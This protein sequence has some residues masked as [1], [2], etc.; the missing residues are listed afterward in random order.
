MIHEIKL[1]GFRLMVRR[2]PAGV[3]LVTRNGAFKNSPI[4]LKG[5]AKAAFWPVVNNRKKRAQRPSSETMERIFSRGGVVILFMLRT[6]RIAG[7]W[8]R[9]PWPARRRPCPHPPYK[10]PR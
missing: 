2:D 1:D 7:R 5:I 4:L 8:F 3:R 6:N 9:E 10:K